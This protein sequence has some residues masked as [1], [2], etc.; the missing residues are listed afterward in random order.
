MVVWGH[1][2]KALRPQ[3]VHQWEAR[4]TCLC[5]TGLDTPRVE[6][7]WDTQAAALWWMESEESPS[8]TGRE[9]ELPKYSFRWGVWINA[10]KLLELIKNR[11]YLIWAK[12][13]YL[14]QRS[15]PQ[16]LQF[17]WAME[18]IIDWHLLRVFLG[19]PGVSSHPH[20][21]GQQRESSS[22]TF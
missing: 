15:T 9:K 8:R 5:P 12:V 14:A 2:E 22:L 20:V 1:L 18:L 17:P 21:L 10:F 11:W 7:T 6:V 16:K 13:K 3:L 4:L 19:L